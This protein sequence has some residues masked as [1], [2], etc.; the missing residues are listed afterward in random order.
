MTTFAD[1]LAIS[2][3]TVVV[4]SMAPL[5]IGFIRGFKHPRIV[6]GIIVG[7]FALLVGVFSAELLTPATTYQ[8]TEYITG[9]HTEV[10]GRNS[11]TS[12]YI[13][14]DKN[15]TEYKVCGE[16]YGKYANGDAIIVTYAENT[17][18]FTH[19]TYTESYID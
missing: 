4:L 12:Y 3:V 19:R 13:T 8:E 17:G 7:V 5:L 15:D 6:A 10:T 1:V 11:T 18:F 2:F 16:T 9:M 14:T